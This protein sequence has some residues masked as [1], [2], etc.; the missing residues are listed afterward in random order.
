MLLL[1]PFELRELAS[2]VFV[3]GDDSA[4]AEEGPH[5]GDVDLDCSIAIENAG[6]N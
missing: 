6:C 1:P 4:K 3:D 2:Q 5:D